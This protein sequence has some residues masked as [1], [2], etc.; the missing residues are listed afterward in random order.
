MPLG[1]NRGEKWISSC[2]NC[3]RLFRQTNFTWN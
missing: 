1:G 3:Q 2:W